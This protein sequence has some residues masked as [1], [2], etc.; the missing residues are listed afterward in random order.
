MKKTK[1]QTF[2]FLLFVFISV[3]AKAQENL[4]DYPSIHVDEWQKMN[5]SKIETI[6]WFKAAKY[7]MFI[8]WGL[9]SMP[10]GIWNGKKIEEYRDP[11]VAE[12]IMHAAQ[13]PRSEYASLAQNFNPTQFSAEKWAM[14][15]KEAGMKYLV[16]TA[17]RESFR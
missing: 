11:F 14:L 16:F 7:G 4:T 6:N 2:I 9:Y 15:A 10:G 1:I 12:W 13:I 17:K 5:A 3:T 8:H